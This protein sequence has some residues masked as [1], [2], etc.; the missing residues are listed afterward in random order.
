MAAPPWAERDFADGGTFDG[1]DHAVWRG[2]DADV[3]GDGAAVALAVASAA[4]GGAAAS[5]RG[6]E[7]TL[8][9]RREE[10]A[11]QLSRWARRAMRWA[12]TP[13]FSAIPAIDC[14]PW[15]YRRR[16]SDQSG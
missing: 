5:W 12:E 11:G 14:S 2:E 15:T 1:V 9:R 6:F 4:G 8:L 16:I 10:R 3:L 7:R 13:C